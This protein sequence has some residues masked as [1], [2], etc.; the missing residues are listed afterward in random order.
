[1]SS[2]YLR[3]V[4]FVYRAGSTF[5]CGGTKDSGDGDGDGDT[6][7]LAAYD[8]AYERLGGAT[9]DCYL[10]TNPTASAEECLQSSRATR[11]GQCER[12]VLNDAKATDW[13]ECYTQEL[14]D[15][16]ECLGD[17]CA[18]DCLIELDC[19]WTSDLADG[20]SACK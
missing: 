15:Q 16:A 1:M 9:C 2:K 4:V 13:L 18:Q 3:C 14:I 6:S 5:A 12:A 8:Q 17:S 10:A 7:P 19:P 11:F 20:L